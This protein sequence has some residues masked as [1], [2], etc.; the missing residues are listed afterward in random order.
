MS[1]VDRENPMAKVA[2]EVA[3]EAHQKKAEWKLQKH[4]RLVVEGRVE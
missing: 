2:S 3:L 4:G 1:L